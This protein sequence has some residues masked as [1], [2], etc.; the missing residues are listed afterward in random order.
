[1]PLDGLTLHAAAHELNALL[2][3]GKIDKITQAEDDEILLSIRSNQKNYKLLMSANSANPRIYLVKEYKKENPLKAPMF[4]M[5]LR[6]HIGGGRILSISQNGF[7]RSLTL[8]IEAYD[9]MRVLRQKLLIIEIMGKHSNIILVDSESGKVTD[10]VKRVP[11]S[12]SSVREVLP[13]RE[14][15]QPPGQNKKNPLIGIGLEEFIS[16]LKSKNSS[17][18]K[19]IYG[20]FE[21]LSPVIAREICFR[22]SIDDSL[23]TYELTDLNYERLKNSFDRLFNDVSVNNIYP[24]II[25]DKRLNTPVEFSAVA[26]THMEGFSVKHG[27]SISEI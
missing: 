13:N 11:L 7:D 21:G 23:S 15:I 3:G 16:V 6:K 24:N 9:E 14:F 4:L 17:I 2:A 20:N 10:A 22:A 26:L 12:M 5:I 25:M 27:E 1:M 8:R 18:L 19:A